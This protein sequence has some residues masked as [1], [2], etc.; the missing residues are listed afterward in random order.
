MVVKC[1]N[2]NDRKVW[3]RW[4]KGDGDVTVRIIIGTRWIEYKTNGIVLD[5]FNE[6][7]TSMNAI[8]KKNI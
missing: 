2:M 7:R 6:R 1:E 3:K 5:E 4:T 8:I